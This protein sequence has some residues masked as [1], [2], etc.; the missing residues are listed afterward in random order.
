M[1]H[2]IR[3]KATLNKLALGSFTRRKLK[4]LLIWILWLASEWNQLD[5]QQ[6]QK[7]FGVHCPAPPNATVL[8]SLWSYVIKSCGTS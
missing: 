7:V 2:H 3:G 5:A 4:Q 8:H 6:K 1:V